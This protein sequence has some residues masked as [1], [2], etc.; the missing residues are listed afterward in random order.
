MFCIEKCASLL[1]AFQKRLIICCVSH[2]WDFCLCLWKWSLQKRKKIVTI[3]PKIY[4]RKKQ[5]RV[6]FTKYLTNFLRPFLSQSLKNISEC[7]TQFPTR[8]T[9]ITRIIV[10]SSQVCRKN[11]SNY[12]LYFKAA[13]PK[14]AFVIKTPL[15]SV[16]FEVTS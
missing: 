5:P 15:H 9:T 12:T 4:D 8:N 11:Y 2:C 7:H 1:I 13:L 14:S 16:A 3:R 10:R 6:V